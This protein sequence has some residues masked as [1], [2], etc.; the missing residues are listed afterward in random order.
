M[1]AKHVTVRERLNVERITVGVDSFRNCV[2]ER[3]ACLATHCPGLNLKGVRR[4]NGL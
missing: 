4:V 3:M 1:T 2:L